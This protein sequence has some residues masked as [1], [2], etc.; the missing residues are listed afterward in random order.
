MAKGNY[1]SLARVFE[2]ELP[3]RISKANSQFFAECPV[4]S[5]CYAQSDT[6]EDVINEIVAVAAS[7]IELYKEESLEVPLGKSPRARVIQSQTTVK[8]PVLVSV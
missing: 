7:L 1:K 5:D 3:V 6:V 2:Y 4:W 8:V